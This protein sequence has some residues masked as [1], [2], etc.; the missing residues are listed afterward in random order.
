MTEITI[1]GPG[2]TENEQKQQLSVAY[3]HA[4]AA[5]AGYAFQIILS[6][7]TV[8]TFNSRQAEK[9]TTR[10]SFARRRS[11]SNSRPPPNGSSK[12]TICL[13]APLEE[14]KTS[15]GVSCSSAIGRL[16]LPQDAPVG[17]SRPR[18]R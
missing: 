4:V 7:M 8:L 17:W 6:M 5:R 11:T 9:S 2:M 12:R 16:V 18:T 1:E 3:V 14:L 15:R 13:S 10:P